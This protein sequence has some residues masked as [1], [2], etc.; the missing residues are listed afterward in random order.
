MRV[1]PALVLVA[2]AVGL[3][4]CASP[5]MP[6][7]TE[8]PGFW[9]GLWHGFFAPVALIVGI[10]TNVRIYEFPNSG[11]WY[12]FGFLL[13]VSPWGGGATYQRRKRRKKRDEENY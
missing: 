13:G 3:T 5:P 4:G 8:L 2:I 7:G 10:F 11:G 6:P 9:W 12:D 1:F